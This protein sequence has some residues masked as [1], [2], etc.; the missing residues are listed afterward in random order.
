MFGADTTNIIVP[1][2]L[3]VNPS[4]APEADMLYVALGVETAEEA[5]Q[6]VP[7]AN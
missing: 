2:P 4:G 6:F 7:V 3:N 1:S 5:N